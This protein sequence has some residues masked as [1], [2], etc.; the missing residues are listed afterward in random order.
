[1]LEAR[2][3]NIIQCAQSA[4]LSIKEVPDDQN[5]IH[6]IIKQEPQG[7]PIHLVHRL[8]EK[9]IVLIIG[10]KAH[11]G[12][13]E[14]ISK[15]PNEERDH[16]FWDLRLT[17][18]RAD[19]DFSFE[20]PDNIY[21]VTISRVI[22]LEE[23]NSKV[24]LE[25]YRKIRTG[26]L[27]YLWYLNRKFG[28]PEERGQAIYISGGRD[29][30]VSRNIR[31]EEQGTINPN[32]KETPIQTIVSFDLPF[33]IHRL[34]TTVEFNI[35]DKKLRIERRII[36]WQEIRNEPLKR[37][38]GDSKIENVTTLADRWGKFSY[39]EVNVIFPQLIDP[40]ETLGIKPNE[41]IGPS[42]DANLSQEERNIRFHEES[43]RR[44]L[45]QPELKALHDAL[46]VLNYFLDMY[47]LI[48]G[49]SNVGNV[50]YDDIIN[51]SITH[52]QGA[53]SRRFYIDNSTRYPICLNCTLELPRKKMEELA[54]YVAQE[55]KIELYDYLSIIAERL[56][57]QGRFGLDVVMAETGFEVFVEQWL[58]K[59]MSS[60]MTPEEID[61]KL[62]KVLHIRTRVRKLVAEERGIPQ[63]QFEKF[64]EFV[65][66]DSEDPSQ[67]GA[68][69]IRNDI[70][71]GHLSPSEITRE[72]A[73]E[74]FRQIRSLRD[75]ILS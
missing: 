39:S 59:S 38:Y 69:K 22:L 23:L 74:A 56:T 26:F 60:K 75:L 65:Q 33:L 30:S 17:L 72:Q 40:R 67:L 2:T 47:T 53:S 21:N 16:L 5:D 50:S 25:A 34:G 46:E 44:A 29:I 43:E 62:E 48:T 61:K 36:P 71:H 27:T 66:W 8:N 9:F 14:K 73:L 51:F 57:F 10:V 64:P 6:L 55:N 68:R 32:D 15:L 4:G 12:H 70:A 45:S 49:I 28:T 19:T 37:L 7:I 11:P 35:G 63:E 41:E 24:L 1:M 31:V 42:F 18:L 3:R 20:P 52:Q 58:R 54:K 13:I